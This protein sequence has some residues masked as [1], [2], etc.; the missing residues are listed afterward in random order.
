[1]PGMVAPAARIVAAALAA[2][3][4]ACGEPGPRAAPPGAPSVL[5]VSIDSLRPDH[6]SCYGYPR[7][8]SPTIDRLASEGVR[9]QEAVSTTSWTLPAHAALLTGLYDAGHGLVD[10]GLRLAD[11]QVTLA[12][13]LRRHGWQTAGFFGGPYLHPTFG[14]AQ[15]FDHYQSC[16]TRVDDELAE[17]AVRA[18]SRA[19][20]GVSHADVTGPRTVAEF[21][22]WL[23]TTDT[24]PF[25]AFVHLWDVHYDFIPPPGYAEIFDP[26]YEGDLTGVG[27]MQN[28]RIAAGMDPR[29]LRHLLALYDGEIRFTDETLAALLKALDAR[30]RLENTIVVVTADHGEE[31]F[32]HD[33]K[34][35]QRTLYEEVVRIPLVFHWKGR[36]GTS[37][38]AAAPIEPAAQVRL[39]DVMPTLLA[40]CG[41]EDRP[42]TNGRDLTPLLRGESLPAEPALTELYSDGRDVQALRMDTY[43]AIRAAAQHPGTGFDLVADPLERTPLPPAHPLVQT[44]LKLLRRE[45]ERARAAGLGRGAEPAGDIDPAVLQRLRSLGYV[46]GEKQR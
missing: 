2:L 24:R 16:M 20:A 45:Q 8:T 27:F 34:G 30:G 1:M 12:E 33:H 39:V 25:L 43:K 23:E 17:E 26:D 19:R 32:E 11:A 28:P 46:G 40:L 14:I 4:A 44:G 5:L 18:E 6:L 29:D 15:G 42:T 35:H 9:F 10:N 22:R 41:I 13:V 36:L 3:A 7:P 31:F 38:G 21:E 37:G